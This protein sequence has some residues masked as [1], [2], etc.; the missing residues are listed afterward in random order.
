MKNLWV[1]LLILSFQV[2]NR[3]LLFMGKSSQVL[4]LK[5]NKCKI[6]IYKPQHFQVIS[7][8]IKLED[9][10]FANRILV[11]RKCLIECLVSSFIKE[12]VIMCD[13]DCSLTEI[14]ASGALGCIV[15]ISFQNN[16]SEIM[17]FP[18]IALTTKSLYFV[19]LYKKSAK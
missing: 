13:Q 1:M 3:C 9:I 12:K 7:I 14:K 4:A 18:T 2:L 15:P 17:P 16:Y 6:Y 11:Y 19:K 5:L 10:W 8:R